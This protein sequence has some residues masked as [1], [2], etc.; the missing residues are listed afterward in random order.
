MR[1]DVMSTSKVGI[2]RRRNVWITVICV[3]LI[4][5]LAGV[6]LINASLTAQNGFPSAKPPAPYAKMPADRGPHGQVRGCT[7]SEVTS[8]APEPAQMLRPS[9]PS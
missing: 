2:H 8:R 6:F 1:E 7:S 9:W 4:A 5:P 3:G